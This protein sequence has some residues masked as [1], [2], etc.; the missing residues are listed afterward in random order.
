MRDT[1]NIL[2]VCGRNKRRSKTAESIFRD[3]KDFKIQSAGLSP[4]SPSQISETKIDWA[5]AILV[6]EDGH[7]ARVLGQFR[8]LDLPAIYVL[9]IED[10]YEYMQPELIEVLE[11]RIPTTLKY[12]MKLKNLG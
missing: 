11:E 3:E 10:E 7:K 4:K 1:A 9:H 12:E 8:H 6:M 5:D 2:V